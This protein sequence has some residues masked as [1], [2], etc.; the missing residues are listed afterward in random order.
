MTD[1]L[2]RIGPVTLADLAV[3]DRVEFREEG[4][5]D[6]MYTG[7]YNAPN[8]IMRD[9]GETG[10]GVDGSW[11]VED[12]L[13]DPIYLLGGTEPE[14]P[15]GLEPVVDDGRPVPMRA[16]MCA[17]CGLPTGGM[18]TLGDSPGYRYCDGCRDLPAPYVGGGDHHDGDIINREGRAPQTYDG[19]GRRNAR[20]RAMQAD[21]AL[22][23]PAHDF[24]LYPEGEEV[25]DEQPI[26]FRCACGSHDFTLRWYERRMVYTNTE[27][28]EDSDTVW[29]DAYNPDSDTG[30]DYEATCDNCGDTVPWEF[31]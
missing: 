18:H 23:V 30:A 15:V 9:D 31:S 21:P 8:S 1:T 12:N 7:T 29:F 25:E 22:A 6:S 19:A 26:D 4:T 20:V 3:G 2:T 16:T 11:H 14:T 28:S 24:T 17:C 27:G 13:N 10:D 5:A